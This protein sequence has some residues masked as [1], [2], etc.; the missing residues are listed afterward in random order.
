MENYTKYRWFFTSSGTLVIGGK[1][2]LQNDELLFNIKN[3]KA[4]YIIMHTSEPGSPFC[5]LYAPASKI[6]KS[7]IAEAAIFTGCFSRAWKLGK[8]SAKV[9]IFNSSQIHKNKDMNSGTWGVYGEVQRT[10]VPLSLVFTKQKNIL[11]AVPEKTFEKSISEEKGKK[12]VS[13]SM[14]KITPGNIEKDHMFAKLELELDD[15][16]SEEQVLSAIPAGKFKI[17]RE[18]I[19]ITNGKN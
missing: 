2:A 10:N 5:I 15:T 16:L 4:D 11:R 1:N 8:M 14:V 17:Q 19:N 9:D 18:V 13:V 6:S 3:Q 7:D 12:P